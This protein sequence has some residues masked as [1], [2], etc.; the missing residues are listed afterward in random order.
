LSFSLFIFHWLT[1]VVGKPG[2]F[3]GGFF[4]T[5]NKFQTGSFRQSS[6]DISD[7]IPEWTQKTQSQNHNLNS[8]LL[9]KTDQ[10]IWCQDRLYRKAESSMDKTKGIQ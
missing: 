2:G 5:N 3:S 6:C 1:L 4:P 9:K 8:T 7:K 10:L